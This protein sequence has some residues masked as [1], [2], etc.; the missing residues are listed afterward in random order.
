[1]TRQSGT[2][3][4]AVVLAGGSGTRFW[5]R[6]RARAPKQL[7]ALGG[8]RTLLQETVRRLRPLVGTRGVWVV[9]GRAH[10]A[11]VRRQLPGLEAARVVVEPQGRNTA[12]AIALAALRMEACT[13]DAVMIVAPSDHVVGDAPALRRA[14]ETACRVAARHEALVTIG[15]PPTH[16]ETGFGYV[17][18]GAPIGRGA[19]G[20]RWAK[21]FV[22]KPPAVTARR[23]VAGGALWNGGIFVWRTRVILEALRAHLPAVTAPLET[24]LARGGP[25]ALA[26]AYRRVPA[27]SIDHG[28]LERAE[29]VAVVPARC[30]WND[31]GS[32]AALEA[33][34]RDGDVNAVRGRTVMVDSRGCVVDGGRRL[35]AVL[36]VDDLVVV[37]APDALLVC[38]KDRAQDV[39]LVV[40]ELRR[41]N[42]ERYL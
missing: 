40:A 12:A 20:A 9:T 26:A 34:W 35:V 17:R 42:L 13:P 14:L 19:A 31:V 21:G 38:A 25:R 27:V 4:V 16:P 36:G 22:E 39:R 5:P 29:R 32:W 10:A 28:V 8:R 18:P 33:L 15:I 30:G 1:M 11:A 23:L 2:S 7:L 41:R 37:D 3:R 24:A 6:S